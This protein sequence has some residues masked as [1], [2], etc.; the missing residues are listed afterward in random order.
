M[1]FYQEKGIENIAL[2]SMNGLY[3]VD[4]DKLK[5]ATNFSATMKTFFSKLNPDYHE[6]NKMLKKFFQIF[7]MDASRNCDF[8][9]QKMISER[10]R[11]HENDQMNRGQYTN[12]DLQKQIEERDK[13]ISQL[14]NKF[15]NLSAVHQ[16]IEG[17]NQNYART[18]NNLE[19]EKDRLKLQYG[20]AN[21]QISFLQTL[22]TSFANSR[23][24]A[25]D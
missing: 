16:R 18:V 4:Y 6:D 25:T 15:S 1:N 14:G 10:D 5:K 13:T 8:I 24:V 21:E 19:N 20:I 12:S 11:F 9:Q 7:K 3:H 2:Q 17:E 22:L 23:P